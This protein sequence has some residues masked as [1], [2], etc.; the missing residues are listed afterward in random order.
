METATATR[1]STQTTPLGFLWLEITGKCQLS[2]VHCYADSGPAG[3]HGTLTVDD[4][5]RIIDDAADSGVRA[6]QFIGGEPT[7]HPSLADLVDHA[8]A[9]SLIVEVYSNLVSISRKL[10]AC[11]QLPGVSLATSYYAPD[12][13]VHD[14]IT[15]VLGSRK[16]TLANIRRALQFAIPLRVGIVTIN[17]AQD[18]EAAR[19]ELADIGVTD[20][21]VDRQRL[22]GRAAYATSRDPSQ[23]CGGCGHGRFAISSTG[24]VWP[25]V[26]ARWVSVGNVFSASLADLSGRAWQAGD[27]LRH[28]SPL[29][30]CS[31]FSPCD[32][33]M[34][35]PQ[36]CLP[37][38]DGCQPTQGPCNPAQPCFPDL[39]RCNPQRR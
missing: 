9:Q 32:P 36:T 20:I 14:G 5:C 21:G 19:R 25:C 30:R 28:A 34:C 3:K 10:W 11:F 33:Q 4:W 2:C 26:F 35:H 6:I 27:E 15:G 23:L 13:L 7:L 1:H 8:V 22:V 16:K 29:Q 17:D 38:Q 12:S 39:Q 31:P 24:D 18:T 37:S